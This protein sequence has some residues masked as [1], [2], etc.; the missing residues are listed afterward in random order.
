MGHSGEP[1]LISK[2]KWKTVKSSAADLAVFALWFGQSYQG[3]GIA[4]PSLVFFLAAYYT[5]NSSLPRFAHKA[6]KNS[7][8]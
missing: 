7:L 6:Y 8:S 4:H 1:R 2:T 3:F 5:L